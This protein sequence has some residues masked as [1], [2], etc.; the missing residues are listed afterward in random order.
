MLG[1]GGISVPV[2]DKVSLREWTAS[3]LAAVS[4]ITAYI[5]TL[6]GLYVD[7]G[8]NTLKRLNGMVTSAAN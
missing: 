8:G 4:Q 6:A 3:G 2:I 1:F 5:F 7:L